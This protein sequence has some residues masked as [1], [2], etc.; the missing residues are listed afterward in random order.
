MCTDMVSEQDGNPAVKS[1]EKS[2]Y[3]RGLTGVGFWALALSTSGT[4]PGAEQLGRPDVLRRKVPI[5]CNL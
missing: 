5:S 3:R 4:N 2:R 1:L